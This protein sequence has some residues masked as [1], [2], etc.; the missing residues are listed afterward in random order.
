MV[1]INSIEAIKQ[2]V[3]KGLGITIIPDIAAAGEIA[4]G[5]LSVAYRD[6]EL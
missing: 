5:S 1:E 6:I 4:Q 2:C 3:S